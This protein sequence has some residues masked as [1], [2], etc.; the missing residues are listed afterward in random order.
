MTTATETKYSFASATRTGEKIGVIGGTDVFAANATIQGFIAND[1]EARTMQDGRKVLNI[2]IALNN[3][4]KKITGAL[5]FNE[6]AD[7]TLW[8][9]ASIFDS[10][11]VPSATRAEKILKKGMLVVLN[12]LIKPEEYNGKTNYNMNVNDFKISWS[13]EKGKTVGGE[14]SFVSARKANKEGN[15]IVAFE[16]F[17]GS[18]PVVRSTGGGDVLSFSVGLN[19]VGNKLNFPLGIQ[20]EKKDLTWIQVNV[21]DNEGF[22]LKSRAEKALK[23]GM[24]IIGHGLMTAKEGEKGHFYNL[25]LSDFEIVRNLGE[26]NEKKETFNQ[27]D[28]PVDEDVPF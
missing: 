26:K 1:P 22:P 15:A 8:V 2:S 16:G 21:W 20:G 27:E 6:R 7:E 9:R 13:K 25:N 28:I 14:Y 11:Q 3:T 24:A 10:E 17:I 18:E 19:K 5:G 12:G 23:K 4:G